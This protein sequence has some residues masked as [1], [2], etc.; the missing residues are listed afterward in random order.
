VTGK[1]GVGKTTLAA[2]LARLAAWSGK[3][4]LVA[5]VA[6]DVNAPSPVAEALGGERSGEEP[7]KVAPGI[8]CVLLTPTMGHRRFLQ[9]TFPVKI[10]ADA[11]MR[12]T[13]IRRFLSAAP[14]FGELGVL[15]RM[16]DLLRKR[17]PDDHFEHEVVIVDSPATGH[18]L[19]I[20]QL[21]EMI[22]KIIPG[23]PIG[24]AV[25]EGL[26]L[27]TDPQHTSTLVVTLPE[28]LP[29]SEA[30][31]LTEG[32]SKNHIPMAGIV[33]NR[34]PQD[35]FTADERAQVDSLNACEGPLLGERAL[36]RLDRARAAVARLRQCS[37]LPVVDLPELPERGPALA[38]R[39]AHVLA[40][41]YKLKA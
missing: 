24:R 16:L 4:V 15:Y 41:A 2:A 19:A 1:G 6:A 35:P 40:E 25:R 28:S 13:A 37:R 39:L 30:L 38:E 23:G 7:V 11:A 34:V 31:E 27:F 26:S 14:A 10:V 22:L 29:V 9:D 36:K 18:A 20:T 8:R 17:R 33:V 12:S 5:E 3:R 21:P 32:L